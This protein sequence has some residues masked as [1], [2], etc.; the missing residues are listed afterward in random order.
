MDKIRYAVVGVGNMG[1]HHARAAHELPELELVGVVDANLEQGQA[2]A[3]LYGCEAFTDLGEMVRSCRPQAV[4]VCVPTSLHERIGLAC[5]EL[6]LNMLMEKPIA[7]SVEEGE[8]LIDA[9][10]QRGVVL[11]AGHIERYNPA[12]LKVKEMIDRGDIG[13]V[14]SIMARRVGV[15]PP[16][17]KDANIAVDLA[18]HDIDVAN[19]LLGETPLRVTS[20]KRRNHIELR[21]DS[22]E[23]F[24]RYSNAS[25]F[26]QAN[27][28]TPVKI[29]KLNITGT[30]GYI[31]MDY[32]N[33]RILYYKSNY[34]KY[35]EDPGHVG[36]YADYVLKY[37]EPDLTEINVA[38]R[39][40]LKE[41]ILHFL[42]GVR[43]EEAIDPAYA[44]DALRVAL[45]A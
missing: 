28:I 20:E 41:E 45:E 40:P 38:K 31:D 13:K 34:E 22:V 42:R 5:I 4:S 44:I 29:R 10:R 16:Q 25:A 7:G 26:I 2:I 14:V 17:I 37:L 21:E 39:E 36:G 23:L 30:D 3:R 18:I 32:V 15:F 12:V 43:G 1:K 35:R 8:R 27:W 11:M 24:L 19:Y 6:G 9:A 33:Q